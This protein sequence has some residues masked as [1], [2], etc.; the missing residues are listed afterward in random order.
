V[1][2]AVIRL[3]VPLFVL[4]AVFWLIVYAATR[5]TKREG[6][7]VARQLLVSLGLAALV[8]GAVSALFYFRGFIDVH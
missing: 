6:L 4:T 2:E 5:R 3:I 7:H 1:R 8:L